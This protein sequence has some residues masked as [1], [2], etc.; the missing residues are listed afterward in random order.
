MS[1]LIKGSKFKV[2]GSLLKAVYWYK[3]SYH[4]NFDDL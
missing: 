3:R 4:V 2:P 1:L